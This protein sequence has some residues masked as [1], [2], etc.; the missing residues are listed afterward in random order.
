MNYSETEQNSEGERNLLK[1][2]KFLV[3]YRSS[4]ECVLAF[5]SVCNQ[6]TVVNL[7]SYLVFVFI[8]LYM[9][10]PAGWLSC[11]HNLVRIALE[12]VM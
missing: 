1:A 6:V 5:V 8:H 3:P 12:L 4:S 7:V 2:Y 11:V 10:T 9:S